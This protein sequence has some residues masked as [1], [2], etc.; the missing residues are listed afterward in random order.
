LLV[1]RL[2]AQSP[3][4]A[5]A[6]AFDVVSIKPNT[7][8]SG[9]PPTGFTVRSGGYLTIANMPLR[10]IIRTAYQVQDYQLVGGTDSIVWSRFNVEA[11][12]EGMPLYRF[13]PGLATPTHPVY[14]MLRKM[15][16]E[17]CKLV[18]HHEMRT[19]PAYDLVMAKADQTLGPRLTRSATDCA[20]VNAARGT[21]HEV[22]R[23]ANGA[24]PC[25]LIGAVTPDGIRLIADSQTMPLFVFA[26]AGYAGR[27]I[28][29]RTGLTGLFSFIIEFAPD[30]GSTSNLPSFFTA[31]E[32]QLG[33][34]LVSTTAPF[35]IVVIDHVELPTPD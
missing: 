34:K 22:P 14:P 11:R 1:P 27:P 29:D 12:A 15:L 17:R 4:A 6:P 13:P 3:F 32:E 23:A 30:P 2:I 19:L 18:V 31:A 25:G 8:A 16:A 35:D 28:V 20:P 26:V 21:D 10:E 33:L 9:A 24:L 5:V 7:L